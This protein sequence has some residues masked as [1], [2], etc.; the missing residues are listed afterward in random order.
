MNYNAFNL[1]KFAF[2][3][4]INN[5]YIVIYLFIDAFDKQERLLYQ[6]NYAKIIYECHLFIKTDIVIKDILYC[7]K[8]ISNVS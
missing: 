6:L 8:I 2:Y 3:E 1:D 5:W 7:A 4:T